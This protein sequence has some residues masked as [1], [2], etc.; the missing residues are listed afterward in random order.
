[1]SLLTICQ[2]VLRETGFNNLTAIASSSDENARRLFGLANREGKALMKRH[3]WTVL[4]KEHT[5][6]TANG[7]ANYALPSD[8]DRFIKVTG[9]DRTNYWAL[10]GPITPQEW[11]LIKSGITQTGPRRRYRIKPSSQ[12]N[13][14]YL[15]PTPTTT[16]SLVFEYISN[17]FCQSSGGTAQ[18]AFA[19]DGDLGIGDF[20]YLITL[21]IKWRW[22]AALG[23]SYAEE[24]REYDLELERAI[25]RD[26]DQP[27]LSLNG[28]RRWLPGAN[29]PESGFG[30]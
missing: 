26:G 15:D 25:A 7:T 8:F 1:M 17:Q 30:S 27:K 3:D 20:E 28:N 12:T 19:A 23:L 9:W 14:I 13:Y 6:S 16:D 4:Q 29:I 2:S 10:Q 5:F 18:S 11:Q 24:R 22:L 21:G